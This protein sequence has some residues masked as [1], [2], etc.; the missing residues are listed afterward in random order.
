[1]EWKRWNAEERGNRRPTTLNLLAPC[2]LAYR[3]VAGFWRGRVRAQ[4]TNRITA[5]VL[6]QQ[7]RAG[8]LHEKGQA[9]PNARSW[10]D[11]ALRPGLI[12]F[13]SGGPGVEREI[14]LL[15]REIISESKK[16]NPG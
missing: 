13:K 8:Q 1:M 5:A 7:L 4:L 3:A 9:R 2:P 12:G 10:T 6:H 14:N 15:V 11:T 16:K